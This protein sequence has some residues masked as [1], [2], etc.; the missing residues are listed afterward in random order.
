LIRLDDGDEDK[1]IAA[2]GSR[3]QAIIIAALETGCRIGELLSLQWGQ[4]RW[5]EGYILLNASK[6]KTN[7]AR[8]V[9]MTSR[10]RGILEMRR[11]DV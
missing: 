2:A 8:S 6:T 11:T 4:V 9:P 3:T 7:E 10:L 1:L 5:A